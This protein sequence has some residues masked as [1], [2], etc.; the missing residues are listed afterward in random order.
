[1]P[2]KTALARLESNRRWRKNNPARVMAQRERDRPVTRLRV[3]R[4]RKDNYP[5]MIQY[6]KDHPCVDC[7]NHDVRCLI[8][9]HV[10]GKKI[11]N[12]GACLSNAWSGVERE[13]AKCDVRCANCHMIRH[14]RNPKLTKT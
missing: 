12:I 5:R 6:L 8:F 4:R 3:A 14:G 9:D 1:M 10:R 7:G 11:S 2:H 13:I